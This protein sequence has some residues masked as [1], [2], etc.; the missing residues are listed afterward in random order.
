MEKIAELILTVYWIESLPWPTKSG[1][2][3]YA[4]IVT[5]VVFMVRPSVRAMP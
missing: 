1:S 3:H 4:K 2:Q 5:I